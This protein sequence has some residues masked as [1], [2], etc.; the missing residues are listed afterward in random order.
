MFLFSNIRMYVNRLE[1]FQEWKRMPH[2]SP[3]GRISVRY[4]V[5]TAGFATKF[6]I[7]GAVAWKNIYTDKNMRVLRMAPQSCRQQHLFSTWW[8]PLYSFFFE[9]LHRSSKGFQ[10]QHADEM[11]FLPNYPNG[12]PMIR[13][14]DRLQREDYG[15]FILSCFQT[16]YLPYLL[17]IGAN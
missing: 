7:K 14:G 6:S 2:A 4:Y 17:S 1:S 8:S 10:F 16:G 12:D 13:D 5:C 15:S 3:P 9:M 11:P